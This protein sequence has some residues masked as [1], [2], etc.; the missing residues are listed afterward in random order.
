[1]MAIK[2]KVVTRVQRY[3]P[4]RNRIGLDTKKSLEQRTPRIVKTLP[5]TRGFLPQDFL[6]ILERIP[7]DYVYA[8]ILG[9]NQIRGVN[10]VK[11]IIQETVENA[12]SKFDKAKFV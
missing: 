5:R 9:E 7:N 10:M 12:L 6:P 1:M 8:P 4:T 3:R 11:C 2:R